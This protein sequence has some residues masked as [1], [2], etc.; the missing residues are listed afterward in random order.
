[1]SLRFGVRCGR[2]LC[3]AVF[4]AP[5]AGCN[6]DG[7][8][9]FQWWNSD[10]REDAAMADDQSTSCPVIDSRDWAAWINAMPGPDAE[11]TLI[12]TGEIDLP[13]PDYTIEITLGPADR[14]M[15]PGQYLDLA[16][17]APDGMVAQVVTPTPV[18]FETR[19]VYPEYRKVVVR[20]GDTL[21][22]EITDVP[23]AH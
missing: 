20:C 2:I 12:V 3:A 5:L 8:L 14:M 19:A 17:S 15:P 21:L 1:M 9:P 10:A 4:L 18:R 7:F 23:T 11:P 16:A 13:T 22:A 6:D